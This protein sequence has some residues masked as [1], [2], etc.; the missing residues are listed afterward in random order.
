MQ[1][2]E[3]NERISWKKL[4]L[5]DKLN[6]DYIQVLDVQDDMAIIAGADEKKNCTHISWVYVENEVVKDEVHN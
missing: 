4:T 3:G 2:E 6:L 1:A 5:F